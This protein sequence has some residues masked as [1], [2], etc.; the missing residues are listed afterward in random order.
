[1]IVHACSVTSDSLW[2]HGLWPTRLLCPWLHAISQARLEQVAISFSR[3]SSQPSNRIRISCIA[4]FDSSFVTEPPGKSDWHDQSLLKLFCTQLP[5]HDSFL[6]LL[7][8]RWLLLSLLCWFLLIS[9]HWS[10]LGV[11]ALKWHSWL[12]LVS[13]CRLLFWAQTQTAYLTDLHLDMQ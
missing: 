5:T 6:L 9:E 1:M 11:S 8:H 13:P 3:G 12:Y 2:P 10:S 4:C 7:S